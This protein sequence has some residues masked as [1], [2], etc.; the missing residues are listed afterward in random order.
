MIFCQSER[1]CTAS[2]TDTGHSQSEQAGAW[3]MGFF[4]VVV[5]VPQLATGKIDLPLHCQSGIRSRC[6]GMLVYVDKTS[7]VFNGTHVWIQNQHVDSTLFTISL[8]WCFKSLLWNLSQMGKTKQVQ[9]KI[10]QQDTNYSLFVLLSPSVYFNK[11][12]A[13]SQS[14]LSSIILHILCYII[15][16]NHSFIYAQP[17]KKYANYLFAMSMPESFL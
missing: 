9:L 8:L 1:L 3:P 5:A 10:Y 14:T 11:H 7:V 17:Y 13:G 12:K 4:F 6:S 16:K 15:S 2:L